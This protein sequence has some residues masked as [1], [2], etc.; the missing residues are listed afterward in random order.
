M[1]RFV[2]FV[3]HI[4]VTFLSVRVMYSSNQQRVVRVTIMKLVTRAGDQDLL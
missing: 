1:F 2:I 4:T 3:N